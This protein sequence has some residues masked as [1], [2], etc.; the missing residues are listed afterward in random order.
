MQL[1]AEARSW[2]V[3]HAAKCTTGNGLRFLQAHHP[4]AATPTVYATAP[5]QGGRAAGRESVDLGDGLCLDACEDV[6]EGETERQRVHI[7][8]QAVSTSTGAVL[9]TRITLL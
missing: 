8:I 1:V 3:E 9:V 6:S 7:D 2:S 4:D 5:T